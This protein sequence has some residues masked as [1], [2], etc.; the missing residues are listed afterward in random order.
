MLPST[1]NF[2]FARTECPLGANC[3][4]VK[5]VCIIKRFVISVICWNFFA[6]TLRKTT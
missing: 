4:L 6:K 5:Y 3:D 1:D 2:V